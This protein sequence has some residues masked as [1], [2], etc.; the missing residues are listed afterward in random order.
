MI[1]NKITTMK[2]YISF[3]MAALV[4]AI[5]TSCN[6]T[7]LTVTGVP[8]TEI[9]DTDYEKI[10]TIGS[11][12]KLTFKRSVSEYTP[13]LLSKN[14]STGR[15]VPFGLDYVQTGQG[16]YGFGC[17]LESIGLVAVLSGM[18]TVLMDEAAGGGLI[19]TG[20]A[21]AGGGAALC[22]IGAPLLKGNFRDGYKYVTSTTNDDLFSFGAKPRYNSLLDTNKK[23]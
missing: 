4:L 12:G 11:D 20:M 8:G 22:L 10:G 16:K 1:F 2:K 18:M 3:V 14:P 21:M 19:A 7:K 5:M 13:F 15:C 6:S 9:I 17:A 23:Y